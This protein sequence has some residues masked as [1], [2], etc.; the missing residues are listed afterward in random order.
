MK[1]SFENNTNKYNNEAPQKTDS[2]DEK[3]TASID[4]IAD[5]LLRNREFMGA[6]EPG[7]AKNDA[8]DKSGEVKKLKYIDEL[9]MPIGIDPIDVQDLVPKS[10]ET[11]DFGTNQDTS[12]IEAGDVAASSKSSKDGYYKPGDY[13]IANRHL[14]KRT[15]KMEYLLV[16]GD[17]KQYLVTEDDITGVEKTENDE[18]N[19][20]RLRDIVEGKTPDDS[21]QPADTSELETESTEKQLLRDILASGEVSSEWQERIQEVLGEQQDIDAAPE[22]NPEAEV[23]SKDEIRESLN[24]IEQK[25]KYDEALQNYA[26]AL[27]D[28]ETKIGRKKHFQQR[29]KKLDY[30]GRELMRANLAYSKEIIA[31]TEAA[32]LYKGSEEEIKR[33]KIDDMYDE[34]RRLDR[35]SR[36]ATRE[37]RLERIENRNAFAKA[38]AKIGEFL[39]RGNKRNFV[40]GLTIGKIAG[41]SG[42]IA[43]APAA[44]AVG[45]A[46]GAATYFGSRMNTL[47]KQLQ[48]YDEQ[49]ISDDK[50]DEMR[51]KNT[52]DN[53]ADVATGVSKEIFKNNAEKGYIS[54]TEAHN[55]AL[56]KTMLHGAGIL[57]GG[58][59]GAMLHETMN[60]GGSTSTS[61]FSAMPNAEASSVPQIDAI[62]PTGT[63]LVDA[64]ESTGTD[65]GNPII[66]SGSEIANT[67]SPEQLNVRSGG[68]WLEQLGKMFGP[69]N[70]HTIY[71]NLN[72]NEIGNF[73]YYDS[74]NGW[75]GIARSGNMPQNVVDSIVNTAKSLN[76]SIK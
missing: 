46:S 74:T 1:E 44:I 48:N 23:P 75:H 34:M 17:R 11:E 16:D 55:K 35:D 42:G 32:G 51:R 67:F 20:G 8:N 19:S 70:A 5:E 38:M 54:R 24:N 72:W 4:P 31:A 15:G 58:A 25:L 9:P 36:R 64:I 73:A 37:E 10:S 6:Q 57:M 7:G 68:G 3:N 18:P 53:I 52:H 33:A 65:L 29:A 40:T 30:A 69:E 39:N 49:A 60:M 41:I 14:N 26:K 28:F 71:N 2:V 61:E 45:A 56:K 62:E 22:D 59:A 66:E 47:D 43:A 63:D 27:A 76:I 21:E 12:K 13:N 50:F